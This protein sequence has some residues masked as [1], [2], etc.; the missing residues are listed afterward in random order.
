MTVLLV[1]GAGYLGS[2]LASELVERGYAVRILDRLYFGDHGLE[3]IRDRVDLVVG[4]MRTVGP[5]ILDDVEAVINV[6][7]LS[8]DP[9]A[10]YNPRANYEMNVAATLSL[11]ELCRQHGVGRYVLASSCSVYDRG[12]G[13]ETLDQLLDETVDVDP[14]SA[15]GGSKIQ[16][17]RGLLPMASDSFCVTA[18]RMGTLFGFSPRM[19][20]DLVVNTFVKDALTKGRLSIHYGGEMWRPLAE[21]RDAARA[22]IALLRAPQGRVN[23]QIFNLVNRN[24]RISEL[25][26]R[27][28]E[29]LRSLDIEAD[30]RADFSYRGVRSY[31]VTGERLEREVGFRPTVSVEESVRAMV[32]G[33]RRL[34]YDDFENPR[35]YNITWM[36]LLEQAHEVIKVTGGVFDAPA[37]DASA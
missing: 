11:A 28:R 16:A 10:E 27:V 8:N 4:D 21:V 35:Y 37:K 13:D 25:A 5:E 18:L 33:I 32:E 3:G 29:E 12:V 26:L 23:G 15:Y 2:V 22:Y 9:T 34:H 31:R 17:E 19:R 24:F 14:P 7:G 30:I 20:Y 36:R 6:G 1:G